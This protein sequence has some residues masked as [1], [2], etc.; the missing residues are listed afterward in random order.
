MKRKSLIL[1]LLVFSFSLLL[2][3]LY[4][5]AIP[6]LIP[7]GDQEGYI[8]IG[9]LIH[10]SPSLS[11]IINPYRTPL[12]PLFLLFAHSIFHTYTVIPYLQ[13][14]IASFSLTLFFLSLVK[15]KIM[16]LLSLAIVLLISLSINVFGWEK[17]LMTEGLATSWLLLLV[18]VSLPLFELITVR[19]LLLFFFLSVLGFLLRP[20]VLPIPIIILAFLL[21]QNVVERKTQSAKLWFTI[22]LYILIPVFYIL[23]NT[24]FHGYKSIQQVG[25]VDVFARI[26]QFQLPVDAGKAY[27]FYVNI[28]KNY[29]YDSKDFRPFDILKS[30]DPDIYGKQYM[31]NDLRSFNREVILSNPVQYALHALS[32]LPKAVT[33]S[34]PFLHIDSPQNLFSMTGLFYILQEFSRVLTYGN[35]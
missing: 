18:S 3:V 1:A 5:Q 19:R 27:P 9:N 13:Y 33:E 6:G 22:V 12:Y 21:V 29:V 23:G 2:R 16:P 32:D 17:S 30:Y 10:S 8:Q 15:Q 26:L 34:S 28:A 25:D 11:T 4:T 24:Y 14:L 20:M 31:F 35:F 7:H